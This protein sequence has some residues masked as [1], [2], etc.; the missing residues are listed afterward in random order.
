MNSMTFFQPFRGGRHIRHIFSRQCSTATFKCSPTKVHLCEHPP[1]E[2]EITKSEMM[3]YFREMSRIRRMELAS[4][5]LYKQRLIRGFCHLYDGQEAVAMGVDAGTRPDDH[6]ITAYRCHAQQLLRGD[7]MKSIIAEMLGRKGGA[8]KGKGGSM[9]LYLPEKR[10]HGGNGI[11]G[12]QVPIGA[13]L[14]FAAKYLGEES[15]AI[16]MYGDGA[17][18]QG[19]VFEAANMAALWKLPCIFL[20]E[21]N[22]YGMGTSTDRASAQNEFYLRGAYVAGIQCD[23]MDVASSRATMKYAADWCRAGNGP[24]FVEMKTYRYHGHSMSDPGK[25]YRSKQEVSGYRNE[26]DCIEQVKTYILEQKWATA[27]ELKQI[28]KE[29]RKEVDE[30]VN[31]AKAQPEP[32]VEEVFSDIYSGK[33]PSFIRATDYPSSCV[34]S[35]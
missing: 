16:A 11:V 5:M 33:P 7:T 29:C 9:H 8:A 21:N 3:H 27:D 20:C 19:Q 12:A 4:D 2:I 26:K 25:S 1:S 6:L 13:G 30:A 15:L 22:M 31:W 17:A 18:N 24:I 10:F 35:Q 14:A 23:G 34:T 28:D 32:D